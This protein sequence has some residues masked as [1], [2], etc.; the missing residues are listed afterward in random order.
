MQQDISQ[1][2][3]VYQETSTVLFSNMR[4]PT[5]EEFLL[6]RDKYG[7]DMFKNALCTIEGRVDIRSKWDVLYNAVLKQFEFMKDEK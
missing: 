2:P 7:N 3:V 1:I 6:L 5:E 4:L